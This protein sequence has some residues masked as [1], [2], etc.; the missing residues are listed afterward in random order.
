MNGEERR[1]IILTKLNESRAPISAGTLA[2]DFSVTRQIIVADIALLRAA[3]YPISAKNR[4]YILDGKE[5]GLIKRIAV[6]HGKEE[7]STEFY[8]I[9]DNGGRVIDVIVH[10]SVYG[11][12]SAE[13]NIT[14]RYEADEFVRKIAETGANPLSLLTE[15]LHI[16]TIAVKDEDTF[17]RIV[18]RL[19][20]LNILIE[21]T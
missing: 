15:G 20:E 13:L 14:S 12:I 5:N 17:E 8:A 19:K 18:K 1:S 7:V 4:G 11:K 9:V 16:H 21:S 3:G 10:H 6:K 2:S